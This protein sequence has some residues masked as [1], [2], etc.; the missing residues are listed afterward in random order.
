MKRIILVACILAVLGALVGGAWM[1]LRRRGAKTALVRARVA[2]QA[3]QAS[4]ALR[5]T[6]EYVKRFP[7]DSSGHLLQGLACARLGQ[8]SKAREALRRAVDLD[9]SELFAT[10]A[11]VETYVLPT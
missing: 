11:L 5:L 4:Q 10:V 2:L 7:E 9:P 3:N 6:E 8:Y 1:Y